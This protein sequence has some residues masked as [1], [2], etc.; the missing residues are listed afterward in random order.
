MISVV[1]SVIFSANWICGAT[2]SILPA[3]GNLELSVSVKSCDMHSTRIGSWNGLLV[4]QQKPATPNSDKV[5]IETLLSDCRLENVTGAPTNR[6]ADGG[7]KLWSQRLL[8]NSI[9]NSYSVL[10]GTVIRD[11]N[12]GGDLLCANTTF[13]SSSTSTVHPI[14][15][16]SIEL[17]LLQ[18]Y[19]RP[20]LR[21]HKSKDGIYEWHDTA[22]SS[23]RIFDFYDFNPYEQF[24]EKGVNFFFST[25]DDSIHFTRCSFSNIDG[26][27]SSD[28]Y[29]HS[30]GTVIL[31]RCHSSLSVDECQFLNCFSEPF[32]GAIECNVESSIAPITITSSSFD[33][34]SSDSTHS[35]TIFH[36]SL[37]SLS[38][39]SSNF[40]SFTHRQHRDL[41]SSSELFMSNCVFHFDGL[42]YSQ[43]LSLLGR[44]SLVSQT[45]FESDPPAEADVDKSYMM[46][47]QFNASPGMFVTSDGDD[48]SA[49]CS[50]ANPCRSL[51]HI[52]SLNSLAQTIVFL[53][54]GDYPHTQMTDKRLS[55]RGWCPTVAGKLPTR[56]DASISLSVDAAASV[57]LTNLALSPRSPSS[58][59]LDTNGSYLT[60][61]SSSFTNLAIQASLIVSSNEGGVD[62]CDTK[63]INITTTACLVSVTSGGRTYL[64]NCAFVDIHRTT[65][66]GPAVL[67]SDST[68]DLSFDESMFVRCCSDYGVVGAL[69][70][71]ITDTEFSSRF[72]MICISNRG[73]PGAPSDIL[74]EGLDEEKCRKALEYSQHFSNGI[75]FG[76]KSGEDSGTGILM[77]NEQP[78]IFLTTCPSLLWTKA[79]E[80]T[81]LH[82][83]SFQISEFV[84][85]CKEEETIKVTVEDPLNVVFSQKPFALP[86]LKL[87]LYYQS[88]STESAVCCVVKQDPTEQGVFVAVTDDALLNIDGFSFLVDSDNTEPMFTVDPLSNL[89]ISHSIVSGDSGSIHRPFLQT[90]GISRFFSTHF[91][92]LSFSDHSCIECLRGA[93]E[94]SGNSLPDYRTSVSHLSTTGNGAFLSAV[95][96]KSHLYFSNTDFFNC[97]ANNGGALHIETEA[98]VTLFDVSFVAC[99][100]EENGGATVFINKHGTID[101]TFTVFC[102]N[103]TAKKGGGLFISLQQYTS[104]RIERAP[105]K[106]YFSTYY[107]DHEFENC[108]ATE[109]GG[110]VYIEGESRV[111]LIR[112]DSVG[113]NNWNS[114]G[115]GTDIFYASGITL[116]QDDPDD[117]I[118]NIKGSARS[119]SL[120]PS[121]N[122]PPFNVYFESDPTRSF[123]FNP[124]EI[125]LAFLGTDIY[126][127]IYQEQANFISDVVRYIHTKDETG[128]NVPVEITFENNLHVWERGVCVD[129][130]LKFTRKPGYQMYHIATNPFSNYPVDDRVILEIQEDAVIEVV[131]IEIHIS[132][133]IQFMLVAHRSGEGVVNG[134][135]FEFSS[136]IE[137]NL[138]LF[139]VVDGT[140]RLTDTRI[141]GEV[142]EPTFFDSPLILISPSATPA[143]PTLHLNRVTFSHL[144][145]TNNPHALMEFHQTATV[146][147]TGLDFNSCNKTASEESAR[148]FVSGP[149]LE[150][151]DANQ[152]E[153]F[154][155]LTTSND[156]LFLASDTSSP[157]SS[158]WKRFP[159]RVLL[160]PFFGATI[161]TSTGGKDVAGCGEVGFN[162]RR[163][164]QAGKNLRGSSACKIV[165]WDSSILNGVLDSTQMNTEV[166]ALGSECGIVVE[167]VGSFLN[168]PDG[169]VTPLL[170]LTR[171]VLALPSSLDQPSLISSSSGEVKIVS[172]SFRSD[173]SITFKLICATAGTVRLEGVD[174]RNN[175]FSTIPITLSGLNTATFTRIQRFF[176]RWTIN[177]SAETREF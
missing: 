31:I 86:H 101:A 92:K 141:C 21:R 79:E 131:E 140:L 96:T 155:F 45:L 124:I 64:Q 6:Y 157:Q 129:P 109:A 71:I 39:H 50:F 97:S 167:Q 61:R 118:E 142:V 26:T 80:N 5:R 153:G 165:I 138:A 125:S 69:H 88:P 123:F 1:K 19:L 145:L 7:S 93:F 133:P 91:T 106:N 60:V 18:P 76:W 161:P 150:A 108:R 4:D 134:C 66:T 34:C 151:V 149:D 177:T 119:A 82:P 2:T 171:L 156:S 68:N 168:S 174:I 130:H 24:H 128:Q 104:F 46:C 121:D 28:E 95:L 43:A 170:T 126:S 83:S 89:T 74:I 8:S 135:E 148:I 143:T 47:V 146:S 103:C 111:D 73:K 172:C 42:N 32:A 77:M 85:R 29:R 40:T 65:G 102:T 173:N 3:S 84:L 37:G 52:H 94:F 136:S 132:I 20:N 107:F 38:I 33:T 127:P 30:D 162:C 12:D 35:S 166:T 56:Q 117:Q 87:V 44:Y 17:T 100:A 81:Y 159:L 98:P 13:T 169:G 78:D 116:D 115:R 110:G 122:L 147:V 163:L 176:L 14:T 10:S 55:I 112:I 11:F 58:T 54:P 137:T 114:P 144:H 113:F 72:D 59:I 23:G 9:L 139:E 105:T 99:N 70:V 160:L 152:W 164:I 48:S 67:F 27:D 22:F 49:D 25:T 15:R 51:S 41:L 75:H 90:S 158:V 63:F 175:I 53:G 57:T 36:Y 62:L 154:E 16:R 120:K